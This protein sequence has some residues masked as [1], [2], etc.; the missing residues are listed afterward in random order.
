MEASMARE[1]ALPAGHPTD[2]IVG[3]CPAIQGLRA[4]IRHLAAFDGVG[5]PYVPTL[6]LQGETGTGKGLVARAIHDSGP[7]AQGPFIEV[8]CAAIPEALLEAELFGFEAG[9]FTDAKRPKPGLFEAADGGALFLDEIDTLPL[10]LQSKL[11]N[12]IEAKRIRRLGAVAERPVDVKLITATHADLG[13]DVTAGHFRADL[14]HRL[15]VVL[16]E[17]PPLRA[18]GDDIL[19]LAQHFLRRYAD[20]HGVPSKRLSGAAE[21]WLLRYDWPGNVR[22][23][24]HLMER[25]TLLIAQAILTPETL[26]QLSL[27]RP[28]LSPQPESAPAGGVLEPL[29]EPARIRQ[30]LIQAEGNVM[31]AA[32]L[33]GLSRSALRHR[34]RRYRIVHP[35]HEN[36]AP[37]PG[38]SAESGTSLPTAL[39]FR[40]TG[41][42]KPPSQDGG[43]AKD[44]PADRRK[45][46]PEA[47]WAQKPVAVLAIS[48]TFPETGDPEPPRHEPWTVAARWE[49]RIVEKV[50]G[51][52]GALLQHPPLLVLTAFGIPQT[53]EQLPQRAVH[54]ALAIRQL[55]AAA[56]GSTE[57]AAG[58]EVR[59]AV[60]EGT[61]LVDT[62]ASDPT[63]RV[64]PVGD[65]LTLPV[66]LLGLTAAGEILLSSQVGRAVEGWYELRTRELLLTG[67]SAER[68]AAFTLVG[69]R[70]QRSSL[71]RMDRRALSRFVGRERELGA[72]REV[73]SQAEGGRG[74]VVGIIG[75]PGVGKSRLLYEFRQRLAAERMLYLE[76]DCSSY[77][78][79][80]L[81][82]PLLD[83]LKTYFQLEDRDDAQR[84]RE[85]VAGRLFA[86]DESLAPTLP[87][88]LTLLDVPVEDPHWQVLDPPQRRQRLMEALKRLLVCESQARPLVMIVENLHWIDTETQAF[89]DSLV[90]SLPAV[91]MLLLVT[92]RPEYQHGWG[93][94]TFYTQLRLDPL[95]RQGAEA[96]LQALLGNDAG[97]G[98]LTQQLIEWTEGNPFF[99]EES[100]QT[101]VET[102]VLAGE[103][104][105]Y[106]LAKALP[107]IQVPATV[108]AVLS[109]RV[110][111]LPSEERSLLQS[112]AVIGRDVPLPL[113]QAI[114]ERPEAAL[115]RGLA[116]LQAAEFLY[117]ARLFPDREY[118][119][120]HAL[121]HEVAYGSLLQERRQA[122][123]AHIVEALE[124]FAGDRV[125]EHVERL[126]Y[127]AVRAEGWDKALAYCRQAGARA[128]ARS[129]YRPAVGCFEQ[130]LAALALLPEHRD[131]LEQAIDL[132][133]D[134]RNALW[135]L[136]EFGQVFD[137]L[138]Q[139]EILA[140]ALG[141]QGRLGRVSTFMAAYLWVMGDLDQALECG[142]RALTIAEALGD[143]ALQVEANY[144]LGQAYLA[145]GDYRRA[146]DFLDHNV[147]SLTD[148]LMQERFGLPGIASVVSRSYLAWCLAELGEFA[149]GIARG[150]EAV[151][152]AE[153]ADHPFSLSNALFGVGFLYLRKGDLRN[154]VPT[155]ERCL[156]LCRLW[157]I[158]LWSPRITAALGSAY[159]L[160]GRIAEALPLLEQAIEQ[161][162]SEK[163]LGEHALRVA[164]LSEAFLLAGRTN[165]AFQ[166]AQRALVLSRA[167]KEQGH[168][169]W[170]LWLLGEIAAQRDPPDGEKAEA[171]CR[172]ALALAGELGMRPLMAHCHLGLSTLYTKLGQREQAC[173]ELSMALALYRALD[174]T[175]W[176]SRAE[177]A[178][179]RMI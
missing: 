76:G 125:A 163:R 32:R 111:H 154:A 147:S 135:L 153:A 145:L 170:A 36:V 8:N 20:A 148:H 62:Q 50:V 39:P 78:A 80:V 12:A 144:R 107:R 140:K 6:L 74:Q 167:H 14:Y 25:L 136:G 71:A 94:K 86:L 29:D 34:L 131:T 98:A 157:N 56:A 129:A 72:L 132:R 59:L 51:F 89:L 175:F 150:E 174:M 152:I 81:Y 100:I 176:L 35:D 116:H 124:A 67:E 4:Q 87:A 52:G 114:A 103:R 3:H 99:M 63:A 93:N 7:R 28:A 53:L 70:P 19:T 41:S 133:C 79:T 15:A 30:A 118:T 77:G 117:E 177:A 84:I 121:T 137:Y 88:L 178:L 169:A 24:S 37:L 60:H 48:V 110:D 27:T 151:R 91:R 83:I 159:A 69:F 139:A 165:D 1:G 13:Q 5:N 158:V 26:E 108:Q 64:L 92:Y 42:T 49:R 127:H 54:A 66:R 22:E 17:L 55:V 31:R 173:A 106:R 57:Q 104:G 112:A 142:H 16:L 143:V 58:P 101:L 33:L 73:L 75:E 141:D 43:D 96:F 156:A 126:A 128:A 168:E 138:C 179:A 9:A 68:L 171:S 119:F 146:M 82:L 130:A 38:T 160:S 134:L 155:L 18:R 44:R 113:L 47:G 109:A 164:A 123:H 23:L 85:K 166:T 61:V 40:P 65:A 95:P 46:L 105:A 122:L 2:A 97:L 11:L 172:Q 102:Q 120:K 161:A 90:E 45:P 149:K 162:A 21:A 10:S 115:H